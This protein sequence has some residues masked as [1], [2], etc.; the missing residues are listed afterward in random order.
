MDDRQSSQLAIR[1]STIAAEAGV[2]SAGDA[3]DT[4]PVSLQRS[5]APCLVVQYS[6]ENVHATAPS[7][8]NALC[9]VSSRTTRREVQAANHDSRGSLL[10]APVVAVRDR[11]DRNRLPSVVAQ[12]RAARSRAR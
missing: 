8:L 10:A 4:P 2:L 1:K 5:A 7:A 6:S 12:H 9:I 11:P 3:G